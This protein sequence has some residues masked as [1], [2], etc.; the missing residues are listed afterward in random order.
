MVLQYHC[1]TMRLSFFFFCF[2]FAFAFAFAF[3]HVMLAKRKFGILI[4]ATLKTP[5]NACGIHRYVCPV[6]S[7]PIYFFRNSGSLVGVVV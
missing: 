5:D 2:C 1:L 6:F 4:P 7:S 3:A